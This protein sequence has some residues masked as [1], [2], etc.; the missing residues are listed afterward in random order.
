MTTFNPTIGLEQ[1]QRASDLRDGDR[2]LR[3]Y[4]LG[5]EVI[6]CTAERFRSTHSVDHLFTP[7]ASR[8]IFFLE[9]VERRVEPVRGHYGIATLSDGSKRVGFWDA[10]GDFVTLGSTERTRYVAATTITEFEDKGPVVIPDPKTEGLMPGVD[11]RPDADYVWDSDGDK[12][13]LNPNARSVAF[14]ISERW[15]NPTESQ[16][17]YGPYTTVDPRA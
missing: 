9:K 10:D 8:K 7:E 2:Y 16:K 1:V 15:E 6:T 12:W 5:D 13:R 4:F 11:P 17:G 14:D 3:A